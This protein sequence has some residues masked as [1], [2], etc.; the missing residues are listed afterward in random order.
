VFQLEKATNVLGPWLP[1]GPVLTEPP[2]VDL[3]A[4]TNSPQ[5]FYR[6]RQW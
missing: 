4:L 2:V 1:L 6:L 5:G 3:G